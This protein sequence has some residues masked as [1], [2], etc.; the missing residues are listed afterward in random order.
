MKHLALSLLLLLSFSVAKS[1]RK[2]GP[3]E[4]KVTDSICACLAKTNMSNIKTKDQATTAFMNCFTKQ[5]SQ[6]I[7]L[8]SERKVEVTDKA[9]MRELGMDIG[10]NLLNQNCESFL[11]LSMTMAKDEIK[12]GDNEKAGITTGKLKRID[13]KEF[14]HIV[15]TDESGKEKTFI[16]LRQFE[17]ADALTGNLSSLI[18]K[19]LSI[20]W[21]EIEAYVPSAKSY[22]PFK[23]IV[24][25]SIE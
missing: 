12:N 16:W 15:V 1:Q 11:N 6:L 17:G 19:K 20:H 14:N 9:A 24:K 23:E 21:T 5:A 18:G 25:V 2:I 4:Q 7:P 22:F 10:K 3:V 13:T 8:A